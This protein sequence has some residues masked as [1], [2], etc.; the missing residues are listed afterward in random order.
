MQ[1]NFTRKFTDI[2]FAV[3]GSGIILLRDSD[4]KLQRWSLSSSTHNDPNYIQD[5]PLPLVFT[6]IHDTVP[7]ILPPDLSPHQY[8]CNKASSWVLDNQ[9]RR[10]LWVPPD[11]SGLCDGDRFVFISDGAMR[12]IGAFSNVRIPNAQS[13]FV[14]LLLFSSHDLYFVLDAELQ[15]TNYNEGRETLE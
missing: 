8:H 5:S 11:S 10:M 14:V 6:P 7:P 3:D 12:T 2:S 9:N 15:A 13:S 1:V 4:D